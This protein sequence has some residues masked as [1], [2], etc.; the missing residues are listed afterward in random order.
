MIAILKS[1]NE[2]ASSIRNNSNSNN[3]SNTNAQLSSIFGR[4]DRIENRLDTLA[5][6]EATGS[7]AGAGTADNITARGRGGRLVGA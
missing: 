3:Y 4:I 5:T 6:K 2:S 1:N 7:R